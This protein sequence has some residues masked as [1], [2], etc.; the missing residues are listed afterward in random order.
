MSSSLEQSQTRPAMVGRSLIAAPPAKDTS[1]HL[2]EITQNPDLWA[3]FFDLDGTLLEIAPRPEEV[4]LPAKVRADLAQLHKRFG[5]AVAVI[6]G[7]SR[8]FAEGLLDLP[9]I[10]V[11]GLHGVEFQGSQPPALSQPLKLWIAAEAKA[12][13]LLFEDKGAAVALHSRLN[14][15]AAP[16]AERLMA[17]AL[18]MAG[19]DYT[20]R[21]GHAV[22]ELAPAQGDKGRA[23]HRLMG[24]PAFKGRFPLAFGDDLTDEA[25]FDAAMILGGEGV[26]IGTAPTRARMRIPSPKALYQWI[27][28]TSR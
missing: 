7:R 2:Q 14:P 25:M 17:K 19:K 9:Q 23:L 16:V 1:S 6:T 21:L 27:E 28:R 12:Q 5:G 24:K 22:V 10:E 18:N 13:G 26:K 4:Q 11:V 3:L 8:A 15:A 20:L